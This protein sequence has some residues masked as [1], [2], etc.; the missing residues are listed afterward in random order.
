[1]KAKANKKRSAL[2]PLPYIAIPCYSPVS[3][4]GYPRFGEDL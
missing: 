3:A 2:M 4:G 1:V